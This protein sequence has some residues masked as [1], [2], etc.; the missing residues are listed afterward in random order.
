MVLTTHPKL[1][2]EAAKAKM[3][4]THGVHETGTVGIYIMT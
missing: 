4:G 3:Q 2:V 1:G